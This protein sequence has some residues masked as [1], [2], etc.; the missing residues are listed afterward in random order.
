MQQYMGFDDLFLQFEHFVISLVLL[1]TWR[2][3]FPFL[4][5][6]VHQLSGYCLPVVFLFIKNEVKD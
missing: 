4:N 3:E 2:Q 1:W 5:A 6:H